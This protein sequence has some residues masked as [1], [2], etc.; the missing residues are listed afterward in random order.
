MFLFL[1]FYIFTYDVLSSDD[2]ISD[3][4]NLNSPRIF[5]MIITTNENLND[6]AKA[7]YES[8][9]NRCDNYAF[10]T[11]LP[12]MHQYILYHLF[13]KLNILHPKEY[14]YESYG[15]LTYKVLYSFKDIYIRQ[16]D[17]DWYLK[18]DD[19]TFV[20]I[21][22][23]RSF[24]K[25]KNPNLPI[26][27]GYDL[28]MMTEDGPDYYHSGGAGYLLSKESL[29]RLGSKISENTN[30]CQNSGIEDVDIHKC[31]RSLGV[32]AGDSSDHLSRNRFHPV[33]FFHLLE[34]HNLEWFQ[35]NARRQ[36]AK[37][38]EIYLKI[39]LN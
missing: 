20:F 6:R 12:N 9:A 22:N 7:V 1:I 2:I 37:V 5:C 17:Y 36:Y 18:A 27:Y 23:L 24:L 15:N 14:T 38:L 32:Y 11:I 21:D 30:Y 10:T 35:F 16:P 13:T 8:W 28:F 34:N 19:D 29:S 39:Y 4:K 31:L 33:P 26:T 25:E 3:S